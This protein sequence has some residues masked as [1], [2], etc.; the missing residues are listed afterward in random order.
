MK[1]SVKPANPCFSSGPCPKFPGY[2]L[3]Q[4]RNTPFG[5]S[6]RSTIGGSKLRETIQR[7]RLILG[8]PSDYSIAIVPASDTGAFELAI[9]NMLGPRGVDVFA[10]ESFGNRWTKDIRKHLRLKNAPV[11]WAWLCSKTAFRMA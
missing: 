1:P 10:W 9:W 11:F 3:L 7:T 8:I 2:S 6:H 5:R 4:L